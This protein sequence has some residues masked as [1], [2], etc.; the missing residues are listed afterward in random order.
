M[1][2][3]PSTPPG[4]GPEVRVDRAVPSD[5]EALV[6]LHMRSLPPSESL[7]SAFGR[8]YVRSA[9]RWLMAET[10]AVVLVA[11]GGSGIVGCTSLANGPYTLK[12]LR[13]GLLDA[14][15]GL[16]ARPATL[17]HPDLRARLIGA[18][19]RPPPAPP[20][21]HV[22]FTVVAAE[23]R[24]LG[25]ASALKEASIQMCRAAGWPGILTAV[26]DGNEASVRL[27]LRA[28]FRE[29]PEL[30]TGAVRM[31]YLP[32]QPESPPPA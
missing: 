24:G 32:L 22:A 7:A 20:A 25:I 17:A 27:N 9:Y 13:H 16:L 3:A 23:A 14:L 6:S 30:R 31:F 29:L 4:H 28:G 18:L 10:D 21:A 2:V 26:H 11:R 19:R 5:L 12:M 8:A 1:M 15:L